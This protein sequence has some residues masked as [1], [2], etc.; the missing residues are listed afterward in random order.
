MSRG[1][2][3]KRTGVS[4]LG[5]SV[6]FDE[7]DENAADDDRVDGTEQ[8]CRVRRLEC[9]EWQNAASTQLDDE[10]LSSSAAAADNRRK[11]Q[12]H[13]VRLHF[14][15]LACSSSVRDYVISWLCTRDSAKGRDF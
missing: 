9:Y 7:E 2:W 4:G 12:Q 13:K 8:E 11:A 6:D 14:N 15:W 3:K 10:V 5:E 1:V